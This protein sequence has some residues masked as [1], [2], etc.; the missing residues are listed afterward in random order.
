M[1][2]DARSFYGGA[3]GARSVKPPIGTKP[4]RD[5]VPPKDKGGGGGGGGFEE[6]QY[7]T[8]DQTLLAMQLKVTAAAAPASNAIYDNADHAVPGD[9]ETGVRYDAVE[10]RSGVVV[11]GMDDGGAG[12]TAVYA[13]SLIHM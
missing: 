5:T 12:S 10:P 2:A 8:V 13:V 4:P 11:Y 7:A 1:L 3:E 9:D 6:V